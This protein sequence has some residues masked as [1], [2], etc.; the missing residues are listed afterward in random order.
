MVEYAQAGMLRDI[1]DFVESNLS[2][3]IGSGALG[4]YGY[5]GRYY[6]AP[7]DMGAFGI[8]YNKA[9]FEEAGVSVPETWEELL[10]AVR[11]IKAAGYVP[12]A[13]GGG[14]RWP[15]HHWWAYLATRLGGE[16]A[17]NAAYG[18]SGS[19]T[20]DPFVRAGELLLELNELEP[21][22]TGY[23]G[24]TYDEAA[25]VMGSGQGAMQ[26]MGQWNPAVVAANSP[27]GEGIGDDLGWFRFPTVA[28]GNGE[29][30]DVLGGGNGYVIGA[31]AP[32]EA[33]DFLDFFL[34]AQYSEELI[35]V[36]GIIPAV[37]GAQEALASNPH[38]QRIAQVVSEAD[39]FQLYY[40]Q[41]LPPAV[42]ET[43]KDAVVSLLAGQI[44]PEECAAMIDESW[45]DAQ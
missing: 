3:R 7:Y 34:Q 21:F 14:D 5:D 23:L 26:L 4:V 1:T 19:F 43:V 41:Y 11:D 24:A 13:L 20:D 30:S 6:G 42:G 40:D 38:S 10:T 22:Q 9:I 17:F 12:I 2:D 29:L 36:E 32:D 16:A 35:D 44:S 15:A 27:D 39:Y 25:A 33:L 28:G 18:G 31:N 45:Q 8:W 37:V